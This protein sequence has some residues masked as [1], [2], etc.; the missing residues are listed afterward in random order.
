MRIF[1]VGELPYQL[2]G[3]LFILC[4]QSILQPRKATRKATGKFE[5]A[6]QCL[7]AVIIS[8][9]TW[10]FQAVVIPCDETLTKLRR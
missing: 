7:I 6:N 4:R 8:G 2:Q 10:N 3:T 5:T 1:K 9:V